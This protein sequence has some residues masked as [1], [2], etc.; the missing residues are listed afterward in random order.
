[1]DNNTKRKGVRMTTVATISA[2]AF[3][4]AAAAISGVV[5]TATASKLTRGV[6]V[7]DFGAITATATDFDDMGLISDAVTESLDYGTITSAISGYNTETGSWDTVETVFTGGRAMIGTRAAIASAFPAYVTGPDDTLIYLEGFT[8]VP[9][10]GWT[11]TV[12]SIAR[13]I[14][15]V[16]DIAGAGTFFEVVAA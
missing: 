10:V 12:D 2:A 9:D 6:G 3:N 7:F 14:K 8:S 4:G 15:A 11:V 5:F 1:M 16:G 13:T